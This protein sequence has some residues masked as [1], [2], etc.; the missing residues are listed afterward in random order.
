MVLTVGAEEQEV[1]AY[2][3]KT[4]LREVQADLTRTDNPEFNAWLKRREEI[5]EGLI[6]Q[7]GSGSSPRDAVRPAA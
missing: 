5:V 6:R 3:L 1:L 2:S 4:Y 7:L